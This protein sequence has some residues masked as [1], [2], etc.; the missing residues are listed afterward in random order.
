LVSRNTSTLFTTW[1]THFINAKNRISQNVWFLA[2]LIHHL[3]TASLHCVSAYSHG[4]LMRFTNI[5]SKLFAQF[6]ICWNRI[7]SGPRIGNVLSCLE[8]TCASA[9][10]RVSCGV[11]QR[12]EFYHSKEEKNQF[13]SRFWENKWIVFSWFRGISLCNLVR[14]CS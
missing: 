7:L 12:T 6:D 1:A 10:R 11:R 13:F 8:N 14:K 3:L 9:I 2:F 5:S 4:K